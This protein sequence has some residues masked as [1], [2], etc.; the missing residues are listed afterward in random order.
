MP[1]LQFHIEGAEAVAHAATPMLAL[2]LRIT[3][4]PTIEPIHS[5]SLRCQM[6][7]EATRRRYSSTEQEILRD[8]F[9]EPDRW[10][11]TVRSMLWMNTSVAVPGFRESTLV[12]LELPCTFDFNVATTKYFHAL[13]SGDI[14]LCILYSGTV[15]YEADDSNLHVAHIPWNRETNYR[16][17]AA[18]WHQMMDEHYPN[19]VWLRLERDA[20][21]RMYRYKVRHG[22][23]S[24]EKLLDSLIPDE[25][26]RAEQEQL[27]V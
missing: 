24:W 13:R 5:I 6:Q 14:P 19:S 25:A 12:D 17:P 3:N 10:S 26:P 7:I 27:P 2:K 1:D 16:L 20:F 18:L 4:Q 11:R 22:I 15:F 23:L 8:L 21:E 9:G